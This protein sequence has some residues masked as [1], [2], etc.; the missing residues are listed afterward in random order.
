VAESSLIV[1]APSVSVDAHEELAQRLLVEC[2]AIEFGEGDR[3]RRLPLEALDRL[4]QH[5]R[6]Y[7]TEG[8]IR[9]VSSTSDRSSRHR[10]LGS[11]FSVPHGGAG[12]IAVQVVIVAILK[13]TI[14]FLGD[15]L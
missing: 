8:T 3:W 2:F 10:G 6:W 1:P 12:V 11:D 14:D 15:L 13:I 7:S 4:Q 9:C 5:R